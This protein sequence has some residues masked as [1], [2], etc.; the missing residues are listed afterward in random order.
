VG[1]GPA[2]ATLQ[3]KLAMRPVTPSRR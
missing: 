3:I 2:Q 1:D